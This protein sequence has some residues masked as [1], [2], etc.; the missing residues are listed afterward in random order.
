MKKAKSIIPFAVLALVLAGCGGSE[1][2]SSNASIASAHESSS[3]SSSIE[4]IFSSSQS[5]E[6]SLLSSEEIISSSDVDVSSEESVSPSEITSEQSSEKGD[7]PVAPQE[8]LFKPVKKSPVN[9]ISNDQLLAYINGAIDLCNQVLS[10]KGYVI[11]IPAYE[12]ADLETLLSLP[13]IGQMFSSFLMNNHLED[14]EIAYTLAT[15]S[16]LLDDFLPNVSDI[17]ASLLKDESEGASFNLNIFGIIKDLLRN[18]DLDHVFA[19]LIDMGY[20]DALYRALYALNVR[21]AKEPSLLFEGALEA[22]P[23]DAT[24]LAIDEANKMQPID[25]SRIDFREEMPQELLFGLAR[26]VKNLCLTSDGSSA[27]S[28]INLLTSL[29]SKLAQDEA[30]VEF[31]LLD[32][33]EIAKALLDIIKRSGYQDSDVEFLL[34]LVAVDAKNAFTR[35]EYRRSVV[36]LARI[37]SFNRAVDELRSVLSADTFRAFIKIAD[38]LIEILSSENGESGSSQSSMSTITK[39]M[40]SLTQ[41]EIAAISSFLNYLELDLLELL[42]DAMDVLGKES[43]DPTQQLMD[44]AIEKLTPAYEKIKNG[45]FL[46]EPADVQ[47]EQAAYFVGDVISPENVTFL[48]EGEFR[49]QS[50]T[51]LKEADTSAPGYVDIKAKVSFAEFEKQEFDYVAVNVPVYPAE[52]KDHIALTNI[53]FPEVSLALYECEIPVSV[54]YSTSP[55]G[56]SLIKFDSLLLDM[57]IIQDLDAPIS[58]SGI[59]KDVPLHLEY[60]AVYGDAA[61]SFDTTF[62]ELFGGDGGYRIVECGDYQL[63]WYQA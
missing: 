5:E 51:L 23:E 61:G 29:L 46:G 52:L 40:Q 13:I 35:R 18:I 53:S 50:V 37:D 7:D 11:E 30:E 42:F 62:G 48:Y 41:K 27:S 10:E 34:D 3:S 36:D 20:V 21:P 60:A 25:H 9:P 16:I 32:A 4:P 39:L 56:I 15:A 38:F 19:T 22:F 6:E 17:I 63:Y 47:L 54:S 14:E 55:E 57:P 45:F 26:C 59:L 33:V 2:S 1:S 12:A 28:L 24:L 8:P 43:E 58:P 49:S 44:F 31:S